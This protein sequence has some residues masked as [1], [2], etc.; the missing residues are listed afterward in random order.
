MNTL[1]SKKSGIATFVDLSKAF[2]NEDPF[3]L[4]NNLL[5]HEIPI[6]IIFMVKH[7]LRNQSAKVVWK[8]TSSVYLFIETGVRQ[9]GILSTF[10]F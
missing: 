9:G 4:V 6:N 7:Y 10:L 1:K 5:E 3:L 2:D 8:D